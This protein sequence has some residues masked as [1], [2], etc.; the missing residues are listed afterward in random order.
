MDPNKDL[1]KD[2]KKKPIV[3]MFALYAYATTSEVILIVIALVA[4]LSAGLVF[5]LTGIYFGDATYSLGPLNSFEDMQKNITVIAKKIFLLGLM[6]LVVNFFS[7]FLWST[8]GTRVSYHIRQLYFQKLLDKDVTW[9]DLNKPQELPTKIASQ[10]SSFQKGS[11]DKMGLI[12]L[13]ISCGVTGITLALVRGWQLMLMILAVTPFMLAAFGLMALSMNKIVG[14]SLTSYAKS[15]G[16]SEEAISSIKT[17]AAFNGQKKEEER[18][19]KYLGGSKDDSIKWLSLLGVSN[20]LITLIIDIVIMASF[21][22]GSFLIFYHWHN[23]YKN[24]DYNGGDLMAIYTCGVMGIMMLSFIAPNIQH[25]TEA[26]TAAT[27]IYS[28]INDTKHLAYKGGNVQIPPSELKGKIIFKDVDFSYPS[29][30]NVMVLKKFNYLFENGKTTA[31]CGETGSGKSTLIQ[32]IEKFYEPNGGDII[33]DGHSL[34]DVDVL[35]LRSNIGYVGQEPVLFNT[36]IKENLKYGKEDATMEEIEEACKKANCYDFIIKLEKKFDTI[37]GREGSKMSG[38]QKQRIAIARA[39]IKKP[40]ILLFDE[41]TSALDKKNEEIVQQS[42]KELSKDM[43][44]IIVAHRLSTIQSA[45][46]IILIHDGEIKEKGTH[47]ELLNLNKMYFNLYNSQA[48]KAIPDEEEGIEG[49]SKGN[50]LMK[51]RKNSA[52]IELLRQICN[53][54]KE[55]DKKEEEDKKLIKSSVMFSHNKKNMPILLLGSIFALVSGLHF[56]ILGYLFG[57]V[58]IDVLNP[59]MLLMKTNVSKDFYWALVIA[60]VAA[61]LGFL[62]IYIFGKVASE[63]TYQ[64]RQLLYRKILSMHIAWFDKEKYSASK[65]NSV[66][67]DDAG[68]I[69][70]FI[71]LAMKF[72]L[73]FTTDILAGV[74]ISIYF[75]WRITLVL[76][77]ILILTI[78]FG[79]VDIKYT[80]GSSTEADKYLKD[81][82]DIMGEVV[83]N[84]RTIVSFASEQKVLAMHE[85]ALKTP[86]KI[87]KKRAIVGGT[88]VSLSQFVQ[89]VMYGAIMYVA[90]KWVIKG[91]IEKANTPELLLET[92]KKFFICLFTIILSGSFLGQI[93]FFAPDAGKARQGLVNVMSIINTNSKIDPNNENG[94][95]SEIKGLIEFKNVSFKY[96]GRD[97]WVLKDFNLTITPNQRVAIVGSSGSGKSTIIQLLERFYDINAGE[98]LIDGIN[99]KNYDISYLRSRF[100]LV[101]QEPVL[102]DDT[103]EENIRY[104]NTSATDDEV[105]EAARKANALSFIEGDKFEFVGNPKDDIDAGKGFKRKVGQKGT[106]ISGGQKQRI[107]IARA[108][109]RNPAV[110]LLDEATSALDRDT[111][112]AVQNELRCMMKGRTSVV[113]AHR[114][115]TIEDS[116]C[117]YV[118]DCGK[119]V[120]NGPH[121]SLME[122]KGVYYKLVTGSN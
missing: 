6:A 16:L 107:A 37:V 106:Q 111:E 59:N 100:S 113:V 118:L 64:F 72:Y 109:I 99:I 101:S 116:D 30:K 29:R 12:F 53:E 67:F 44:V 4:S 115:A 95:K 82:L 43:T 27:E 31:I 94:N 90:I 23:S 117:I 98:I 5:P 33:I 48:Q 18:Y 76:L 21:Y 20:G 54:E 38:G 77:V 11:G 60:G 13:S 10:C 71:D 120:E 57:C 74:G 63:M 110:L 41:A 119:I 83:K 86:Q 79:A 52:D 8:V 49:E 26:R 50:E 89:I 22:L 3:P 51:E 73:M 62:T 15:G 92:I 85:E 24:S 2:K 105:R 121:N 66:M 7:F 56:P 114:L 36:S 93:Q 102:F 96:A 47:T 9:F 75:N 80:M 25:V 58:S 19:L 35:W 42:L 68:K 65:L 78:I 97:Q 84:Y 87:E 1:Q 69:N 91:E 103:I 34:K 55:E 32:L 17:V 61:I 45:N 14:S 112:R 81:A 39:L 28:V 40:K 108:I 70:S 122:K 88:L 104:G 46:E